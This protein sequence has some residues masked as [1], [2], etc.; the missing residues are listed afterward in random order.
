M[1]NGILPE[2]VTCTEGL[3]LVIK[4]T[5]NFPACIN[6]TSVEKLIQRG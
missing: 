1:S 6:F 2:N 5:N 4:T 3:T